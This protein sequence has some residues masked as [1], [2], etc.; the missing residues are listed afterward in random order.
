MRT[1]EAAKLKWIDID[2]E[3]RTVRVTPVK[4]G[5]PRILPI[6]TKLAEMLNYLQKRAERVFPIRSG[7]MRSNFC[8]QRK[9]MAAK[10]RNPRLTKIHFH[11]L[12][13]WKATIEYH[14]TKDIVHVKEFLGHK[15]IVNT[16]IYIHIEHAIF[17][18]GQPEQFHVRV[19]KEPEQI[20]ELLGAGF[21]YVCE[22]E[23]TLFFRKRK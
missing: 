5:L 22:K 2:F 13:H 8:H 15:S 9:V 12:R 23:G 17:K 10:L 20:K 6:S 18:E 4:G 7:S 11:T 19:A 14:R 21:D 1:G 16:T 3:R